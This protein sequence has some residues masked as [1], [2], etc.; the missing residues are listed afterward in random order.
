MCILC[1]SCLN[2]KPFPQPP[3]QPE[4]D[5]VGMFKNIYPVM[6][7]MPQSSDG[8]RLHNNII[9][10]NIKTLAGT[11]FLRQGCLQELARVSTSKAWLFSLEAKVF[12][13]SRQLN[14]FEVCLFSVEAKVLHSL[15]FSH[16]LSRLFNECIRIGSM[17]DMTGE[18]S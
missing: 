6:V 15:R 10:V 16:A 3:Y 4:A 7:C 1:E 8:S 11:A 17:V 13:L 18:T 9:M 12:T 5:L 14:E 2:P